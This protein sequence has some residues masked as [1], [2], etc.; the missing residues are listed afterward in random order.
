MVLSIPHFRILKREIF[1]GGSYLA[2]LS[3]PHF[4]IPQHRVRGPQDYPGFQFLILGY[5][6]SSSAELH[7]ENLSIPHFRIHPP[8]RPTTHFGCNLSIPHFRIHKT[9]TV[10][11]VNLKDYFQFLILGYLSLLLGVQSGKTLSI[12]HFRIPAGYR[13]PTARM[14]YIFQFLI[15]GYLPRGRKKLGG[16]AFNSSF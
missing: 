8:R 15:L 1:W 5:A 9:F 11:K 10:E 14:V 6:G 16:F 2:T 13:P 3:I 12:P 4:R 7:H